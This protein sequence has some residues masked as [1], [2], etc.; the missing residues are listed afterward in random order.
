MAKVVL[1]FEKPISELYQKIEELKQISKNNHIDLEIEIGNMIKRAE[2]LKE[3]IF[4]NL[5]P[6][7]IV[8]L[9]R[10]QER[11]TFLDYVPLIFTDFIEMHGD[12]VY[13]DDKAMVGGIA[14]LDEL[15]VMI[16]GQQRGKNTKENVFRNFGM[17]NP[18]GY[19]KALRLMQLAEKFRR[20][21]ITFIDTIGAY[22]GIGA[23]ERGQAEA[24]ARNLREMSGLTVP[25]ISIVIGEGGSGGALGIAVGNKV[26]M[27]QYA[28]YSVISPEGCASILWRDSAKAGIAAQQLGLTS[29][30]LLELKVV[31]AIIPE[32]VGGAHTNAALAAQNIT[33]Y[34]RNELKTMVKWNATKIVHDRYDRF[35]KLG[36]YKES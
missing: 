28:I 30:K 1:E 14:K 29:T 34:L 9:A 20:P 16:I 26:A 35:R 27:L 18:E 19:R 5:E 10:H 2:T 33:L 24:I 25:V 11:P 31:D 13:G 17:A 3:K 36:F 12:R 4:R 23:E 8:Q 7:Q 21:I 6:I 15:P 32:P 22:P